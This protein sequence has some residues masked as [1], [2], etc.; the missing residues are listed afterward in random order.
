[1]SRKLTLSDI[2]DLREYERERADFRAHVIDLKRRRRVGLGPFVTVLF[3]NRDTIRFQI[4]E[5]ARVEKLLTDEAIEGELRVYN[6]LVPE[7][8]ELALT[9][10]IELTSEL[11]LRDWL[12]RLVGIEKT[13]ELRIGEGDGR[14]VVRCI[15]DEE[16]QE[17]LTREEIT[18]SVHY[19]HFELD[20]GQI[21]AFA[22][23]PVEL[24]LT[25]DNYEHA[26][27]LGE[28]T[29]AELLADLRP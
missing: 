27:T 13:L 11:A 6:P 7:P 28:E 19:I 20:A 5:M 12:P 10:F 17:Q 3:E 8:G 4:Q 24:A 29:V 21:E 22:A 2:A 25:H 26:T 23:G 18:A 1:M 15:P 14:I 16:H 9:L